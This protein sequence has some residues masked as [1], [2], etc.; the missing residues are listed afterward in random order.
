[1]NEQDKDKNKKIDLDDG[2]SIGS[3]WID[4]AID[5]DLP[6]IKGTGKNSSNSEHEASH[7]SFVR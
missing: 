4:T 2:T 5:K 1:M 6:L 3:D 7:H